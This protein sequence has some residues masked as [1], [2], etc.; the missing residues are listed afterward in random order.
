MK[1]E[2]SYHKKDQ[3]LNSLEKIIIELKDDQLHKIQ[4]FL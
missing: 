4:T 2:K 1:H 3:I